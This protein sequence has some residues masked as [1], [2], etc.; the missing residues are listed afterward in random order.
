VAV[1]WPVP[2]NAR[3]ICVEWEWEIRVF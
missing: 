2:N 1:D 3:K